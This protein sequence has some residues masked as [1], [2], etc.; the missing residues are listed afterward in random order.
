MTAALAVKDE[1]DGD[2]D[3]TVVSP[4]DQFLSPRA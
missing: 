4:T 2:V 1:L 3:V